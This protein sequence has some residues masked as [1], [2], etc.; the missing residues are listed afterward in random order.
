MWAAFSACALLVSLVALMHALRETDAESAVIGM[1]A[2]QLSTTCCAFSTAS[3]RRTLA[4]LSLLMTALNVGVV[5]R[6]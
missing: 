1:F 4:T 5:A 6:D 2:A 3:Y